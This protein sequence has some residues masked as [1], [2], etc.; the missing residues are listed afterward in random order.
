MGLMHARVD[1]IAWFRLDVLL[2]NGQQ[3]I[4]DQWDLSHAVPHD[5]LLILMFS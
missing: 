3:S 1:I 4:W 5:L 2:E